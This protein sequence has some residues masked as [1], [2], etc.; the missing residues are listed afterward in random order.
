MLVSFSVE[1]WMSFKN[2]TLLSMLAS[3]EQRHSEHLPILDYYR[4]RL[5]PI[6]A[7]FGGNASGKTNLFLAINFAKK[8]VTLG[9]EPD[10]FIEVK[11]FALDTDC[12]K[13]PTLIRFELLTDGKLYEFGFKVTEKEVV[14]EWLIEI[15]KTSEKLIYRRERGE[16]EPG[17][18]YKGDKFIKFV[19]KGTREN[20]L[21][22]TNS[23]QQNI[24]HF[25]PV[26]NWFRDN[27]ILIAPDS[28]FGLPGLISRRNERLEK[29]INENLFDFDTG[30]ERLGSTEV[31]Y[32][33]SSFDES[34]I[35]A[36]EKELRGDEEQQFEFSTPLGR[37]LITI[38]DGNL[39]VEEPVTYH[40][41]SNGRDVRFTLE[42]ESDG[43]LRLIDL[44]PMFFELTR[45]ESQKVFIVDEL[46][47]SLHTLLTRT[48]IESYLATCGPSARS[49][50]IFTTH[51]VAL[52]DQKLLRRDE[53]TVTER[54]DDGSTELI[55]FNEY[56]DIRYD[57]DIRKSYLQGRLGGVPKI[58]S[59]Y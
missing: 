4:R 44:L 57:R 11:S 6:T 37:R 22:L 23:V 1:N 17:R 29:Y 38:K 24:T 40:I 41:D 27:L 32:K 8:L 46:D 25:K 15:L 50:M 59:A 16:I 30:I 43:T 3:R 47:R 33:R 48:L 58:I 13:S 26:Y 14:E 9:T 56:K 5:L 49:Q 19:A 20:Q 36:F 18:D 53:M 10:E 31:S 51:D 28:R 7:I 35:K 42:D 34:L 54:N 39:K 55:S 12:R 21:F 52:M 2:E 45:E